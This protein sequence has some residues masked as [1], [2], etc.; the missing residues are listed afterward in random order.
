[1]P[2]QRNWGN[3]EFKGGGDKGGHK[4]RI[5]YDVA[6]SGCLARESKILSFKKGWVV[7]LNFLLKEGSCP[8]QKKV[9]WEPGSPKR[10][11]LSGGTSRTGLGGGEKMKNHE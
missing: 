5:S 6:A 1:M 10:I 2:K 3:S 8:K 7:I 4:G 9:R 11:I